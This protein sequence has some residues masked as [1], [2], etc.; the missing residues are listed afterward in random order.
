MSYPSKNPYGNKTLPIL[1][2]LLLPSYPSKNPYGN[3]T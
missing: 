1:Y 3:K 2:I